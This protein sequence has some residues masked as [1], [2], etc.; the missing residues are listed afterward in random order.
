MS[1]SFSQNSSVSYVSAAY[2]QQD[3]LADDCTD[4][5]GD[6]VADVDTFV[7]VESD[8]F[9]CALDRHVDVR[10][11]LSRTL[12]DPVFSRASVQ[13]ELL[14]EEVVGGFEDE[15]RV[16]VEDLDLLDVADEHFFGLEEESR[17]SDPD[18]FPA[19]LRLSVAAVR[20]FDDD[21]F[22]RREGDW[23]DL[24]DDLL[25]DAFDVGLDLLVGHDPLF[26]D[27][28][29][30]LGH[31]DEVAEGQQVQGFLVVQHDALDDFLD[32]LVDVWDER[33]DVGVEP[34]LA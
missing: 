22:A 20:V 12:H 6:Q 33:A 2:L 11:V 19:P 8:G 24:G 29:L 28:A 5:T 27:L 10:S 34:G 16:L 7:L 31:V 18:F 32:D 13:L 1:S 21:V 25:V 4:R 23:L 15:C 14:V 26:A 3:L 17:F 30:L 9:L